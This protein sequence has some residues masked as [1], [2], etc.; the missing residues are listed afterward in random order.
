MLEAHPFTDTQQSYYWIRDKGED[1]NGDFSVIEI[2]E[3]RSYWF[4]CVLVLMKCVCLLVLQ[5]LVACF[6]FVPVSCLVQ[7]LPSEFISYSIPTFSSPWKIIILF[8]PG[9]VNLRS[10]RRW[11]DSRN[12][13]WGD[14]GVRC[15]VTIDVPYDWLSYLIINHTALA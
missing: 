1:G 8:R 7:A 14:Q 5:S 13:A 9:Q 10:D 12:I 2:V 6:V 15:N 4:L 3:E 11:D